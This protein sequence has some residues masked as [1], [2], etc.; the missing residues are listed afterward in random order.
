[1][2]ERGNVN[3][4][5]ISR[6]IQILSELNSERVVRYY[7]TQIDDNNILYIHM[8]YCSDNLRNILQNKHELFERVGNSQMSELEYFI[9][10]KIFIEILEAL[11]ELHEQK[12]PIIHRD[13]KPANILFSE[14][15][16]ETGIFFKLCDFGLAKLS[17]DI[18]RR[19]GETNNV[20]TNEMNF[21]Q[22]NNDLS[23]STT[24]TRGP[25][26]QNY[27]APEVSTGH[28]DTKADVYSLSIVGK[29]LFEL[30]N[31]Q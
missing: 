6:E 4:I 10:C 16:I 18:L 13:I 22:V 7:K 19:N 31:N 9:S 2:K 27:M 28:Y 3:L 17:D 11:N 21:N 25:G 14:K 24:N 30:D 5:D 8:E 29:Q 1:M 23:M 26:T 20:D 15:G 12:Q